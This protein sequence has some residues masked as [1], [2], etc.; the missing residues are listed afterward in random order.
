MNYDESEV[1][2]SFSILNDGFRE[3]RMIR[4]RL[5]V[6]G[7]FS[8][9]DRLLQSM[10]KYAN[11]D[12]MN[13]YMVMNKIDEA[14]YSRKGR[15]CFV[16]YPKETTSDA[17]ITER[18]WFLIDMDCERAK[19]V[20][21]NQEEFDLAKKKTQSI[22]KHLNSMGFE[23]PV[24]AISGNGYHLL[25]RICLVN[26]ESSTNLIK[27]CLLALDEWFSDD[28]IKIDTTVFNAARITKLYGTMAQKGQSTDERPHRLSRIID[29]PTE[30]KPTDADI[31]LK[32]AE[33]KTK[34]EEQPRQQYY[35]QKNDFNIDDFIRKH[36]I[37]ITSE[38]R[39]QNGRRLILDHCPFN[40]EHRGKD[41]ALFVKDSG[42][43]GFKCLHASCSQNG[44]KEFR[45]HFEPDAY[46]IRTTPRI[47]SKQPEP[48][49]IPDKYKD[50]PDWWTARTSK[51]VDRSQIVS[52]R[53]GF[54]LLDR[55][56]A[57]LNKGEV[58]VISGLNSSGKTSMLSQLALETTNQGYK[59][60]LFSGEM[61]DHRVFNWLRLQA[62]GKLY[63]VPTDIEGYYLVD[64]S[65][66]PM[67]NKWM[68]SNLYLYN[69]NKGNDIM[70]ILE[71]TE[72]VIKEKKVDLVILDNLM[73]MD[74]SLISGDK[75]EKQSDFIKKLMKFAPQNDV[76]IILVAHP[77]KAMGFLRKDDISGTADLTNAVDNVFIV[78]RVNND[79]KRLTG[80]M[81]GWNESC[82]LYEKSNVIEVCKNRDFGVQDLFVGVYYENESKRFLNEPYEVKHYKWEDQIELKE[83]YYWNEQTG[84]QVKSPFDLD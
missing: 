18:Q 60:A 4:D 3:V 30:I 76:H 58:S 64:D 79:F 14:C 40:S 44:W 10:R 46:T 7:Y 57:G 62:A 43:Y 31:L 35:G 25:Y 73:A 52:I 42:G 19:G 45:Q 74:L 29:I 59:T 24:V 26:D 28:K 49:S 32:L 68:D 33:Q 11:V 63:T 39:T 17:N 38:S 6:S 5:S 80:Q 53:T 15:D 21:S 16:E 56:I 67:I 83:Q 50:E 55:K 65:A 13:F 8:S 41:A 61:R 47:N 22:Y 51:S 20:S 1:K 77:R 27:D 70:R 81:F 75:Y 54:K 69:N 36:N 37:H 66:E 84:Q 9:A 23:K 12:G 82:E 2:K 72:E 71:K 48:K 78:H 34:Q